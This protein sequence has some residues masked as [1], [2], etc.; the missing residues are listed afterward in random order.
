MWHLIIHGVPWRIVLT[1]AAAACGIFTDINS[2]RGTTTLAGYR[3]RII[4]ITFPGL[5]DDNDKD[6]VWIIIRNPALMPA[7]ELRSYA[8]K[9]SPGAVTAAANGTSDGMSAQ[10]SGS[11]MDAAYRMF[12]RLII[13]W[14]V[15][16]ATAIPEINEAGEV[17]GEQPLLPSPATPDTIARLPLEIINRLSEE[18]GKAAPRTTP[19]TGT[20]R[21]S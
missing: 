1:L 20:T 11:D 5:T 16:D 2:E 6:P 10:L 4:R 21:K 15:Y 12:S 9:I 3:D 17:I 18:L 19:R 7:D 14:R 8:D 13:A